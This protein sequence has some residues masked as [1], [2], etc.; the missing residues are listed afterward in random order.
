M[1]SPEFR[2]CPL[3]VPSEHRTDTAVL[4]GL[5][6]HRVA[7]ELCSVALV[8]HRQRQQLEAF[9]QCNKALEAVQTTLFS[10]SHGAQA[11]TATAPGVLQAFKQCKRTLGTAATAPGVLEAFKRCNETLETVQKNLEDYLETKR[12]SFP[13]CSFAFTT[14]SISGYVCVALT[15]S[16]VFPPTSLLYP[17]SLFDYCLTLPIP[18]T[19][20]FGP[21]HD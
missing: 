14:P 2:E 3:S 4:L 12:V 16:D 6:F 19:H 10:G 17:T 13:S 8:V 9:K 1:I 11:V 7:A 18:L 5:I 20:C 21:M 15:C